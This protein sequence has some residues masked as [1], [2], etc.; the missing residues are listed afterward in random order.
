MQKR[1]RPKWKYWCHC[2]AHTD[3]VPSL[4]VVNSWNQ[5]SSVKNQ[6]ICA[7]LQISRQLRYVFFFSSSLRYPAQLHMVSGNQRDPLVPELTWVIDCGCDW[8]CG[9]VRWRPLPSY[10][11]NDSPLD[12]QPVAINEWINQSISQ[13]SHSV[14]QSANQSINTL[15]CSKSRR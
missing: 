9:V 1:H 8:F 6:R 11:L 15:P 4:P 3:L 13:V 14:S 5:Q 2:R 12:R 10:K 7:Q